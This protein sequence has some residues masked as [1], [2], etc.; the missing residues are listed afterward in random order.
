MSLTTTKK[1]IN[2]QSKRFTSNFEAPAVIHCLHRNEIKP[3]FSEVGEIS[4]EMG[5]DG[6]KEFKLY[7]G[8]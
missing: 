2:T 6:G 8:Y 7:L 4:G 5:Q 3:N 1:K